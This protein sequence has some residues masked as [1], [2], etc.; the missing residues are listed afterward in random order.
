MLLLRFKRMGVITLM[1][2]PVDTMGLFGIAIL[3]EYLEIDA[4][5]YQY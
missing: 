2:I 3:A 5:N 4:G 1:S